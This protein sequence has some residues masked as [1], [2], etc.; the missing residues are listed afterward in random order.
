M[1]GS[2]LHVADHLRINR[3]WIGAP[4][5]VAEIANASGD[6]AAG[7][8]ITSFGQTSNGSE[9]GTP[10]VLRK[11]GDKVA[12][13]MKRQG[14]SIFERTVV[15]MSYEQAATCR[16]SLTNN[17]RLGKIGLNGCILAMNFSASFC[18]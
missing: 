6:G 9:Y 4:G 18:I 1:E 8:K 10:E 17:S 5:S 3:P 2:V 7:D 12:E 13:A 16:N 15:H 11:P 14:D